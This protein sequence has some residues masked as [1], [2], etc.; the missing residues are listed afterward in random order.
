MVL[1]QFDLLPAIVNKALSRI[2]YFFRARRERFEKDG[3]AIGLLE[4]LILRIVDGVDSFD[5]EIHG[6]W[7]TLLVQ[8]DIWIELTILLFNMQREAFHL[9]GVICEAV[10]EG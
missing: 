5:L 8:I 10:D 3:Q 9:E 4:L 7:V 6:Q 1:L 2:C